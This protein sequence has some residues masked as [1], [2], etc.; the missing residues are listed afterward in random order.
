MKLLNIIGLLLILSVFIGIFV[1]IWYQNGIEI[2]L[3]VFGL[4]FFIAGV[5]LL[6][7]YLLTY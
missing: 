4:T 6:G 5:I 1:I 3:K 7:C 2:A